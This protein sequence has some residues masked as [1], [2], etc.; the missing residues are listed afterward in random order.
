[1][2]AIK[3]FRKIKDEW[4]DLLVENIIMKGPEEHPHQKIVS[5]HRTSGFIQSR[6]LGGDSYMVEIS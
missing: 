5:E 4:L 1:M 6:R 3:V 2:F